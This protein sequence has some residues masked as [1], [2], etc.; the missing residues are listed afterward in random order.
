[1][2]Q[3]RATL[4]YLMTFALPIGCASLPP[5]PPDAMTVAEARSRAADLDG[6]EVT[7]VGYATIEF[8]NNSV[9][10]SPRDAERL[11]QSNCL[12]LG[13]PDEIYDDRDNN[14]WVLLRGKLHVFP[15]DTIFLNGCAGVGFT[16]SQ[17]P[18]RTSQPK[19]KSR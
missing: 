18:V 13:I 5:V 16:L 10:T 12:G 1:M 6:T 8:E 11:R 17:S 4:I 3:V 2:R 19:D 7:V 14:H 15:K 9:W